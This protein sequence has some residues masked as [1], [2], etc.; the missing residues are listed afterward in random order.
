M[1]E[2]KYKASLIAEAE[3]E[4]GYNFLNTL[5]K[6]E[7]LAETKEL[8]LDFNELFFL[9]KCGGGSKDDFDVLFEGGIENFVIEVFSAIGESGFLGK[10]M[11]GEEM[12][13][14]LREALKAEVVSKSTKTSPT[15]GENNNEKPSE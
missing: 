15:S 11:N 5:T 12:R 2:L 7:T 13:K 14:M 8:R 9:V 10:K 4:T 1:V 6:L 3:K